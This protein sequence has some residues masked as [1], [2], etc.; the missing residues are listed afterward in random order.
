MH[1][2]I[3]TDLPNLIFI[4]EVYK[5]IFFSVRRRPPVGVVHGFFHTSKQKIL[6]TLSMR[7]HAPEGWRTNFKMPYNSMRRHAPGGWR[8]D[9]R[10]IR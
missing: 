7:Q 4:P 5:I 10:N 8:M 2:K 6:L 1:F 3:N 9:I